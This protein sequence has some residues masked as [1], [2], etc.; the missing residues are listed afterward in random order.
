[1]VCDGML[2]GVGSELLQRILSWVLAGESCPH[3]QGLTDRHIWGWEGIFLQGR[4]AEALEV[5]RLPLQP[6]KSICILG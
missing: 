1:M 3:A 6:P 2:D 5:S 4:L